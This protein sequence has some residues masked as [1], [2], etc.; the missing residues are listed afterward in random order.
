MLVAVLLEK[1]M[2]SGSPSVVAEAV[3]DLCKAK[4][5]SCGQHNSKVYGCLVMSFFEQVKITY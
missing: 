1:S 3:Y 2:Q 5:I 4:G